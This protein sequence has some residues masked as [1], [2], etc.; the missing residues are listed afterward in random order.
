MIIRP[1]RIDIY[2]TSIPMHLFEHATASRA[3]SQGI[4]VC[5]TCSDG[6]VGWGETLPREYVTGETLGSVPDD[7]EKTI[8]PAWRS[9]NQTPA[10][11][12]PQITPHTAGD[13]C[14]NAAACATELAA[15]RWTLSDEKAT[16]AVLGAVPTGRRIAA[17]VSGV[18]GSSDPAATARRLRMMRLYGLRDFKLKLGLDEKTDEQNLLAVAKQL[19]G[20][21]KKGKYTLRVDVNGEWQ[22][23]TVPG[24]VKELKRFGVCVVEQPAGATAEEFVELAR[25]CNLP[26][27]ADETLLTERDARILLGEPRRVWW[28][29]RISKNGGLG[30]SARLARM[31]AEAGVKFTLGCMVGE[32]GILSAAQRRLLE[33]IPPPTFMEGNYGRFLLQGDIT[34]KSLRFGYGGRLKT[35]G[36]EGLGIRVKK[37]KF[38]LYARLSRTLHV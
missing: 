8:I 24:R 30:M 33:V 9:N 4:V 11:Y 29:I 19:S 18:L 28:N 17:R 20:G 35:L 14:I 1:I 10:A 26:L 25:I 27:M 38:N 15:M 21:I 3:T 13:R 23:D 5:L 7:I 2:R 12:L 6:N 32:S 31:A 22:Y 16:K 36:S 34:K 37:S